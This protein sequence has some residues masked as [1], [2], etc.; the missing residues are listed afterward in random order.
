MST[1][2]ICK[3]DLLVIS[4]PQLISTSESESEHFHF[5]K[6]ALMSFGGR[7]R[8]FCMTLNNY[9]A[10]E[11]EHI[12]E[13]TVGHCKYAV[14]AH[15]HPP[16]AQPHLQGYFELEKQMTFNAVKTH[17]VRAHFEPRRGTAQQ[18]SDYC[19]KGEQPH[20]EWEAHGVEGP[21]YGL[22]A[23]IRIDH[24]R[25]STQGKRK[26]LEHVQDLL[27]AGHP[28]KRIAEEAPIEYIKFSKG[29]HAYRAATA[30]PRSHE[31]A[32]EIIVYMGPTGTGK[33]LKAFE[34]NPDA[35]VQGPENK[36]KWNGYDQHEVVIWDEFRGQVPF[37][38]FLRI[39]DRYRMKVD[40]K[41]K[42]FVEFV[43]DKIIITS[44]VHPNL[45]YKP[46]VTVDGKIDQLKRRISKI[47]LFEE[48]G[49]EPKDITDVPWSNYPHPADWAPAINLE[50]QFGS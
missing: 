48:L 14:V 38:Y 3:I 50:D 12:R 11:L 27:N 1:V 5:L 34:E 42:E 2:L 40:I 6:R 22:N 28:M 18:A 21:T 4:I 32:K 7:L 16:D 49:K 26:E 23:D 24:G 43:A 29:I 37:A 19:R 25:I 20:A 15:E 35:H 47:L 8:N 36:D 9:T 17:M 10:G 45:W 46:T 39:T 30:I 41:C 13:F 31:T 44:P 33:T